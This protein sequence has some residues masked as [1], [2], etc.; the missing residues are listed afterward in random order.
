MHPGP[1]PVP[2]PQRPRSAR[3]RSMRLLLAHPQR[4]HL[5]SRRWLNR[6][7][8]LPAR[9][10]RLR[11]GCRHCCWRLQVPLSQQWAR[12][13]SRAS[14]HRRRPCP[15]RWCRRRLGSVRQCQDLGQRRCLCRQR[16]RQTARPQP[17][18]EPK[19]RQ[20]EPISLLACWYLAAPVHVF[21]CVE[22]T[23]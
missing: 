16:M 13:S 12:P 14:A 19:L 9:R 1:Q 10:P 5:Q 20:G 3:L 2:H 11:T 22:M 6:P 4:L 18:H 21:E 8:L 15:G 17:E 7:H 23:R